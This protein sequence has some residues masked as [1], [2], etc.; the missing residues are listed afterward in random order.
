MKFTAHHLYFTDWSYGLQSAPEIQFSGSNEVRI[1]KEESMRVSMT[2]VTPATKYTDSDG[3][4][5]QPDPPRR[6]R[7]LKDSI[8]RLT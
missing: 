5:L 4:P 1:D 7:A 6:T 2:Y 8:L 3:E